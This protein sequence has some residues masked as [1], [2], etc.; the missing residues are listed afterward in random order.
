MKRWLKWFG[1]AVAG[2][3]GV[4]L[5][6]KEATHWSTRLMAEVSPPAGCSLMRGCRRP[7]VM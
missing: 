5:P 4:V 7:P 1:Y 3:V 2:L 6:P